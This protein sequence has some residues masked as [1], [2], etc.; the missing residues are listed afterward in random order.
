MWN[1]L[2]K[3]SDSAQDLY[4]NIINQQLANDKK[5]IHTTNLVNFLKTFF[6][7][8]KS[9]ESKKLIIPDNLIAVLI[10]NNFIKQ[11]LCVDLIKYN[12]PNIRVKE[13]SL[14][15]INKKYHDFIKSKMLQ[16]LEL[17]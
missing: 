10:E 15:K 11:D 16:N 8:Y 17:V 2:F 5:L 4:F 6:N 9:V 14:K 13:I 7:N 1:I 3:I 12:Y